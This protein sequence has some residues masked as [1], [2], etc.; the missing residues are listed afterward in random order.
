[1]NH[2]ELHI[3]FQAIE[4]NKLYEDYEFFDGDSL[5][6]N[7]GRDSNQDL[8]VGS[9]TGEWRDDW[10]KNF[11]AKTAEGIAWKMQKKLEEITNLYHLS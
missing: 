1:M 5:L 10:K 3:S 11:Y 2:E 4:S 7:A 6:G 9:F 8:Y